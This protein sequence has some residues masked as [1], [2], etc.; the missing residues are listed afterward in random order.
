MDKPANM[1]K[2]DVEKA[3]EDAVRLWLLWGSK[4]GPLFPLPEP[5]PGNTSFLSDD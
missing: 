3:I 5:K 4:R 1:P 2:S